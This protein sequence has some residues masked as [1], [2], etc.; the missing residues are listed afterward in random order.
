MWQLGLYTVHR[1]RGGVCSW[2][3]CDSKKDRMRVEAEVAGKWQG[4]REGGR[5]GQ[6]IRLSAC[7]PLP[8]P[9]PLLK[10]EFAFVRIFT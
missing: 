8:L 1:E 10:P 3:E 6:Q 9:V 5:E 7:L 2:S 4:G